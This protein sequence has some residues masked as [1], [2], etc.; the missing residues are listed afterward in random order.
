[1][2]DSTT[3]STCTKCGVEYPLTKEFFYPCKTCKTGFLG[4]CRKCA[5]NYSKRYCAENA[6]KARERA[7]RWRAENADK[8]HESNKR[9]RA[10]NAEKLRESKKRYYAEN[11]DKVRETSKRYRVENADKLRDYHKRYR[12]ENSDKKRSYHKRWRAEN[13]EKSKA[14]SQR[15]RARKQGLPDSFTSQDWSAVLAYFDHKCAVCGRPVGLWHT[16]AAD[17]WI[18]LNSLNCPGTIP[19]NILPLC[20]G[21]GGCNN[22]KRDR[23]PAEWLQRKYP[24]RWRKVLARIDT[25][26]EWVRERDG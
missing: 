9:W 6:D 14:A 1:M 20:H 15:R 4:A 25:Y 2:N 11:T 8:A 24:K 13:T 21:D 7:K 5:R 26:F 12:D 22:S 17:H 18:P 16:L 19:G 3:T 23:D 10:E